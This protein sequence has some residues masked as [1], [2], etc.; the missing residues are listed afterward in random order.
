MLSSGHN[1]S[2]LKGIQGRMLTDGPI[3]SDNDVCEYFRG[4]KDELASNCDVEGFEILDAGG[5]TESMSD[6]ER[7]FF[8]KNI[9][10]IHF[11]LSSQ[12][13][14][15]ISRDEFYHRRISNARIR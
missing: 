14:R 5:T 2:M 12:S 9:L 8:R 4:F 1:V 11:W 6:E 13:Y 15:S 10:K 7:R 3:Y